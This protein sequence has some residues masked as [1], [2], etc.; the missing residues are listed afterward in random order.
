[1]AKTLM[2][3]IGT[4]I[5]TKT[6]DTLTK[7]SVPVDNANAA[8]VA[9]EVTA[10]VKPIVTNATNAE[11]LWQS[12]VAIGS[13][14]AV[15]GALADLAA[16]YAT[17]AWEQQRIITDLVVVAGAAFALYGRIKGGLKPLGS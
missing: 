15:L 11:P 4:A 10:A 14:G 7:P 8:Q 13:A 17:G 16:M 1:M 9:R 6:I 5:F 12:R 2:D 3:A